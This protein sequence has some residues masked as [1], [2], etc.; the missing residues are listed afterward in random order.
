[1][2]DTI[3]KLTPNDV[4]AWLCDRLPVIEQR[5]LLS[6]LA[7]H[8]EVLLAEH[9]YRG[10]TTVRTVTISNGLGQILM[11]PICFSIEEPAALDAAKATFDREPLKVQAA[12]WV[13][14]IGQDRHARKGAVC[15]A[16]EATIAIVAAGRGAVEFAI[17]SAVNHTFLS[18]DRVA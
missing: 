8:A 7:A 14:G 2:P 5:R 6:A 10:Q 9:G 12:V 1:M 17:V 4:L 3:M 18:P 13:E 11:F 16:G 15:L